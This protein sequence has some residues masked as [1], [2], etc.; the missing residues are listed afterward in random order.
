MKNA[1]DIAKKLLPSSEPKIVEYIA[2]LGGWRRLESPMMSD[3]LRCVICDS[4]QH[5]AVFCDPAK[6]PE[7]VRICA[8]GDCETNTSIKH[9]KATSIQTPSQRALL[10][11]KFCEINGI[12]D[13]HYD[14][15]FEMIEQNQGK[16]NFMT[17][18]CQQ[19]Q[20]VLLMQGDTGCG[21]TFAAMGM[22][23]LFTR[24]NSSCVFISSENLHRKWVLMATGEDVNALK[25]ILTPNM[26]V[27]DDFG[28][29]EPTDKFLGFIME[30]INER[31]QW[32]GKGTVITTNLRNE[33]LSNYCGEAL[34]DRIR[35]GQLFIFEGESRR[36]NKPL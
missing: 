21:K 5:Y 32:K 3:E 34:S 18:F 28:T 19:P 26:L 15:R 7:K 2:V 11:P 20:G 24:H 17:K 13:M 16:V 33:K 25:G 23:E 30:L 29:S 27:I 22:C 12:G 8:N 1:R 4:S 35:S 36:T 6:G 14:I 31:N 9:V 10:W